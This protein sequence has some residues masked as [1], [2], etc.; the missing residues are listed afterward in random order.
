MNDG[1]F[2][3]YTKRPR[4][5]DDVEWAEFDY[6]QRWRWFA[7]ARFL[8]I[9]SGAA[10]FARTAP[11]AALVVGADTDLAALREGATV[12]PRRFTVGADGGAI[13]FRD[14]S[15]DGVHCA[16]VIEHLPEPERMV[17][18]IHRVLRDDGVVMIRTPDVRRAGFRFWVDHTHRRPFTR[19][20]LHGLLTSQGFV[21]FHVEYGPFWTTRI[22]L[23]LQRV[24]RLPVRFRYGVRR[25]LGQRYC[26][27]LVCLARRAQ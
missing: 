5:A 10:Y 21:V 1:Y 9:G 22:E 13:P 12:G 14:G 25:W 11:S 18:E 17:R 23:A 8:D 2:A 4:T 24:L 26:D 15:F 19:Q 6:R 3:T 20:S 16:H 7:G 27:E